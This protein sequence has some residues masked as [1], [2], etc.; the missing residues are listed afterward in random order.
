MLRMFKRKRNRL[1]INLIRK[2]HSKWRP[3]SYYGF[4]LGVWFWNRSV[5]SID[6]YSIKELKQY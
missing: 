1:Y 3:I 5:D 2:P 6:A 4:M